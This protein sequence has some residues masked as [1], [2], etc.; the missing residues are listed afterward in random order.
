MLLLMYHQTMAAASLFKQLRLV[1]EYHNE[2]VRAQRGASSTLDR[3][4]LHTGTAMLR[5]GAGIAAP[6]QMRGVPPPR[7]RAFLPRGCRR[8]H[9]H[10]RPP[11]HPQFSQSWRSPRRARIAG[12]S[13]LAFRALHRV[14][15][16]WFG[17]VAEDVPSAR[18]LFFAYV[19]Q[20]QHVVC[21]S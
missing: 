7:P 10:A 1:L 17:V 8:W 14:G 19:Q 6:L 12:F 11:P 5:R 9:V 15:S 2:M 21:W 13:R 20:V 4:M 16:V 3:S 18:M